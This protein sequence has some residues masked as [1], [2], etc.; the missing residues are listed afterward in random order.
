MKIDLLDQQLAA[1]VRG[2]IE[3]A[4]RMAQI[5]ERERPHDRRGAGPPG[6]AF[7]WLFLFF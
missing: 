2:D 7:F 5:L 4:W 6:R 1:S 3:E